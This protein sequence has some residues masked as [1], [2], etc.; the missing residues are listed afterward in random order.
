[1][2]ILYVY[3]SDKNRDVYRTLAW[4]GYAIVEYGRRQE[5]SQLQ[6][7][8]IKLLIQY[9]KNNRI[10]HLMSTH[11]IYNVAVAAYGQT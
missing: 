7:K 11:L 1:M 3:S 10:T 4:L 8:E 9:I 2:K 5:N 6:E